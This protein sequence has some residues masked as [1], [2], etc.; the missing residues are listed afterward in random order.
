MGISPPLLSSEMRWLRRK[1]ARNDTGNGTAVGI[2]RLVTSSFREEDPE[3][4]L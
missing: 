4:E 3:K 2:S 1:R